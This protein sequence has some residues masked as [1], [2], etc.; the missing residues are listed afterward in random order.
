MTPVAMAHDHVQC[1]R[2][3]L[4]SAVIVPKHRVMLN[5]ATTAL[6]VQGMSLTSINA[7]ADTIVSAENLLLASRMPLSHARH[8]ACG[9]G[10]APNTRAPLAKNFPH[11]KP[12]SIRVTAT[13]MIQTLTTV[14][15]VL[16]GLP[17]NSAAQ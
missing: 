3:K 15:V 2:P 1:H 17:K 11:A 10:V 12:A 4:D 7:A 5:R 6:H 14:C 13:K 16:S 9:I 8:K